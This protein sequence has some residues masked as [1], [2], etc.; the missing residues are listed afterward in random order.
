MGYT[1]KATKNV[2]IVFVMM[3][4]G[5]LLSLSLRIILARGLAQEEFGLFFSALSLIGVLLILRDAGLSITLVKFVSEYLPKG[6]RDLAKST[7]LI[8]SLIEL[9]LSVVVGST[10]FL[11]SDFLAINYFKIPIASPVMKLISIYFIL[12][13]VIELVERSFQGFQKMGLYSSI[14]FVKMSLVV[15]ATVIFL[16]IGM[17]VFAPTYAFL[18]AG[19]LIP[20]IY[21]PVFLKK[22]FPDFFTI[23]T[24]VDKGLVKKLISFGLPVMITITADKII[25][26]TDIILLT[27]MSTL[28]EVALYNAAQPISKMV[29]YLAIAFASVVLPMTSELWSSGKKDLVVKGCEDVLK[30]FFILLVPTTLVMFVFPK[31]IIN[32]FFGIRYIES[33]I[34]LQIFSVGAI[35]FSIAYVNLFILSG[36]GKP[37]AN[38]VISSLAALLNIV[39]NLFFIPLYGISGAA[40]ATVS[41]FL[42]ILVLSTFELKKSTGLEFPLKD[43][44]KTVLSGIV[45]LSVVSV[46]KK[47]LVAN[48]YFEIVLSLGAGL[49]VFVALLFILDVLDMEEVCELKNRLGF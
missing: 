41:S 38:A 35:F 20:I 49:L 45:F 3:V 24:K 23:G 1:G 40:L 31:I 36:I 39:G 22:V 34:V 26:N 6:E 9:F 19:L 13:T 15:L 33:A 4:L 30:Y 43:W 7:I 8:V 47:A 37:K 27:A 11:L 21:I 42:F 5:A 14:N 29:W 48:V 46:L 25:I 16:N 17:G 32:F 10:L 18:L 28:E 44:T 2:S 12:F